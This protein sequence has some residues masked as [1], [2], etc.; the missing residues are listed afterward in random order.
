MEY[1]RRARRARRGR[2]IADGVPL[3]GYFVWSL[4]DNFEWGQGYA[5]RF[6]LFHVDYS[7]QARTARESACWYREWISE[8]SVEAA[9]PQ[10]NSRRTP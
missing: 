2:P 5:K 3:Q 8:R 1:L 6:G 10:H 7:T 4:M 9:V